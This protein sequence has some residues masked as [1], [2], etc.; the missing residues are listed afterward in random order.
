MNPLFLFVIGA[1]ISW[2]IATFTLLPNS[3]VNWWYLGWLLL[4]IY[5]AWSRSGWHGN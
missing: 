2:V 5:W 1:I 3:K 4:L